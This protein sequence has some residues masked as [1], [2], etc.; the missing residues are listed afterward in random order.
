MLF[1]SPIHHFN[2]STFE[3][4][5]KWVL[6]SFL[7]FYTCSISKLNAAC[8]LYI[9]RVVVGDCEYG[10]R[11]GNNSKVI[12]AVYLRWV[13][14]PP[15]T[16]IVVR[17][18]GQSKN[19]DPFDKG[20]P[21][22]IQFI[23]DPDGSTQTITA[24]FNLL[25]NCNATPV[26][27]VLPQACD[28][29][30]CTGNNTIGG[31]VFLDYN[32][33]G[34]QD[35]SEIGL[36]EVPINV[37]DD[38]KRI[39]AT[40][41]TKINGIWSIPNLPSGLKVRVEFDI[42]NKLYDSNVGM[43]SRTRVQRST[44]G[45]CNVNLGLFDLESVIEENPWIVTALM[46]KGTP[47]NPN[48]NA[49]NNGA[50]VMN[51]F[52]TSS[53]G[54]RI[55]PNGNYFVASAAEVG[56]IWGLAY[57]KES[58]S[59]FSS[60]FLKRNAQLGTD[61]LGAIY[62]TDLNSFLPT[63][64]P[65]ANFN[66]FGNTRLY[67]NLDDFGIQTGDET[68]LKRDIGI[69]TH[70]ASHDSTVFDYVGKW[71]LADIDLNDKGDSL[72]IMNMYNRSLVIVNIGNPFVFP[73]T[74]D[75]ITE[76]PIPD[77]G[78]NMS[79]DW[80]P[81]GLKYKD[82]NIYIGGLCSAESSK[83]PNDLKASILKYNSTGFTSVI[84]FDLLYNKGSVSGSCK[85]FRPWFNNYY[86]YHVGG[87]Q[88]CGPV[89]IVSDIEFDSEGNMIVGI[90][91]RFGYQTGGR[92]YGTK[93][94]DKLVYIH[95][96]GGDLL[97]LFKLKNDFLLEKNATSGFYTTLG[98]NNNQGICKGEYFYEDGFFGHEES[99]LGALA[100]HPSYNTVL[101]TMMDP[102]Q[103]WSNGWS[104]MENSLGSKKV[105]YNI[106]T[107]ET[108]TFGKSAGLGDIE[109]LVGSSTPEGIGVSIGN[110]V[111]EDKDEDGLQDP[112]ENAIVN[113]SLL[114]YDYQNKLLTQTKT[115]INGEFYFK[116]LFPKTK[117]YIQ[118]G[119]SIEYKDDELLHNQKLYSSTKF[120]NRQNFGSSDNDSDAKLE[121]N[122][123]S[124]FKNKMAMEY[125]TGE[126]GE[127]DFSL[128]FGLIKCQ[129]TVR[130][131]VNYTVCRSDSI[132]VDTTWFSVNKSSGEILY[133][134]GSFFG[135]DSSVFINLEFIPEKL[136]K[137]DSSICKGSTITLHG[138]LFDENHSSDQI[139]LNN[140]STNGCD[141][142]I[143]VNIL[144]KSEQISKLD[145]S[146]CKGK[147]V[148]LYGLVFDENKPSD[149]IILKNSAS[150]G[151][152]SLIDFSLQF[153]QH[154][155]NRID[156]SICQ[157]DSII[158]H[159][160]K[161]SANN[162][163][164]TIV[165]KNYNGC[166]SSLQVNLNFKSPNSFNLDTSSCRGSKV[167]IAGINFDESNTNGRIVLPRA[168]S[169]GCDSILQV[170][171]RIKE[172]SRSKVDTSICEHF[173]IT[174]HNKTF[175][176]SNLIDSIRLFTAN[177]QFCDSIIHVQ[178]TLI[179]QAY[180]RLDTSTCEGNEVI[181]NNE[182]FNTNRKIGQLKYPSAQSQFCDSI[183]DVHLKINPNYV[184]RDSIE[185]CEE[186]YWPVTG[187][188]YK[189]NQIL[190][191]KGFSQFGCDSTHQLKLKI[192]PVYTI[193]DSFCTIN[194][195]RWK[196]TGDQYKQSGVFQ[197]K[198]STSKGCDSIRIL[199]LEILSEGEVYVPNIWSPNGDDI[200]D[201]LSVFA[202]KDVKM[203]DVYR[204]FDRWGELMY[205]KF[206]FMPNNTDIGWDGTHRGQDCNPAVFVYYVEWRDKLGGPHLQYGDATLIR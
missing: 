190:E 162:P 108:G 82:G 48:S 119:E 21:P 166:D 205:E 13:M 70:D 10:P 24:G 96:A 30:V 174:L 60:A 31:K 73:I 129:R 164:G 68:K 3:G 89:P 199:Y 52:N 59:L 193:I 135:C 84:Q 139:I 206:N 40:T 104:Q 32:N 27:I 79:T 154:S 58:R 17:L 122:S 167:N 63:P 25:S 184:R 26:D 107:G 147:S 120:L 15:G 133:T 148:T 101:A 71:G 69:N 173:K 149:R 87:D 188:T 159:N 33:N 158:L 57:Q 168:S 39:I 20:C 140:A 102:A 195:Y 198:L 76:I 98:V 200:N 201:K 51:Q 83:D 1:I 23:L 53:G 197:A 152:D 172:P 5:F 130:D 7:L 93:K 91:D 100:I 170:A 109:I 192:N 183:V 19:F 181:I 86:S 114:L 157:G 203:I 150:N 196:T 90:G 141:S 75:R 125:V 29:P 155:T 72:F 85:N 105:N 41:S 180:S 202:N 22:Y 74:K 81:W 189:E 66:Y 61:G 187:M 116:N 136:S 50:I 56:S 145:S 14:P 117:Y 111:W 113:L 138:I 110:Y 45:N 131:T 186:Y 77:Q 118:L 182:I 43:D 6:I 161:F 177:S 4:H 103:I 12:V 112:G 35:L 54:P 92:D 106:F 146:V 9:D 99:T 18:K 28:P 126:N 55:G 16:N 134:D 128:D 132:Q 46:S 163:K 38:S 97:K 179:P 204:I 42:K 160:T 194:E 11:T 191:V 88:S 47:T 123:G 37:F 137:I 124:I 127:N 185:E 95:F 64:A 80:R 44:V 153:L 2:V 144:F 67:F 49:L 115:D 176:K 94:S 151:C 34:N 143:N 169:N 156:Y 142:L 78:C 121:T 36:P 8:E 62:V 175:D 65:K 165:L 178:L 171:L